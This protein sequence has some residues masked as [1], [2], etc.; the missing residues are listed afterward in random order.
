MCIYLKEVLKLFV[1]SVR[2]N[3][4]VDAFESILQFGRSGQSSG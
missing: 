4:T 2:F 3:P 1:F